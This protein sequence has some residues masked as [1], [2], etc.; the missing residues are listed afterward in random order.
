MKTE[1]GVQSAECGVKR[2]EG[3]ICLILALLTAAALRLAALGQ[4]PLW[5]DELASLQRLGLSFSAHVQAMKGN[6][7]LFELLLRLWMPPDG[8]DVWM[9]I[10]S[11]ALGIAAVWMTWRLVRGLGA[12]Y[13]LVAAW[14]MALSPLH[15]MYSRIARPYSLAC[16]LALAS[17]LALIWAVRRRSVL[18]FAVYAFATALMVYAN[19]FAASL[20]IAQGIFLLW[21]HR[22]R[23]RRLAPWVVANL[24][25]AALLAPWMWYS[26][27]G[28]VTWSAQTQYTA[29]QLGMLAK[30]CYLPL[31]LCLGET[32]NPLDFPVVLPALVGFG[33]AIVAGI[34]IVLARR[35]SLAVLLFIQVAVVFLLSLAFPAIGAKHLT[36]LLPAW[37]GLIAVGLTSLRPRWI[38]WL[39]GALI[40]GTM[41]LSLLN[42]FTNREFADADMVTPWRKMAAVVQEY[43]NPVGGHVIIGYEP[44]QGVYDIFRRYYRGHE[45]ITYLDF[46][47][48]QAFI[49][50]ELAGGWACIL[51]HDGDP[52][53]EIEAWLR[54]K[55]EWEVTRVPFQEREHTLK[56]LREGWHSIGKYR[57]P[58]YRLYI[59]RPREGTRIGPY[60]VLL[61][62]AETLH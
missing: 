10:P 55:R 32:V 43:E 48:W 35:R 52:W 56:E 22:R 18:S 31:T 58:L 9:R 26:A 29:Q 42:Y 11:A 49:Q 5:C 33:I 2:H 50:R 19:L 40:L 54:T 45:P 38:V 34:A 3:G 17:T 25:V 30:V 15:V 6:H 13:G 59:V 44:D 41:L 39:C 23:L 1:C 36:I 28:A 8:S 21:F 12:R 16:T 60:P 37:C 4:K 61:D 24:A 53:Q 27:R 47:N 46:H 57:L 14:L 7:P 62:G 20:W 51:L